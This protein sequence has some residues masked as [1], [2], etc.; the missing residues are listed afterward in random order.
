MSERGKFAQADSAAMDEMADELRSLH[1][2]ID[3]C[4]HD[5]DIE[6]KKV[7]KLA[8]RVIKIVS[9]YLPNN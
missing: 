8:P 5:G 3:V 7:C 4:G 9:N 2:A 1:F 6:Y